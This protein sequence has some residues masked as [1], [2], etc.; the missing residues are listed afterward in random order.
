MTENREVTFY[1]H[2]VL[3]TLP[4]TLWSSK[5]VFM[6]TRNFMQRPLTNLQD[7]N[8]N[9]FAIIKCNANQNQQKNNVYPISTLL[10]HLYYE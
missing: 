10:Y 4:K 5:N 8:Y 2:Q 9:S 1:Y 3:L 6:Y 7:L